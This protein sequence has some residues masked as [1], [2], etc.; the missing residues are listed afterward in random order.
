M[1]VKE[2]RSYNYNYDLFTSPSFLALLKNKSKSFHFKK[3]NNTNTWTKPHTTKKVPMRLHITI[4]GGKILIIWK[5]PRFNLNLLAFKFLWCSKVHSG[6]FSTIFWKANTI[7]W[8]L[9][10]K[11]KVVSA[12]T[13]EHENH[14]AGARRVHDGSSASL[15]SNNSVMLTLKILA[16]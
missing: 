5:K 14:K 11:D 16:N 3:P 9:E 1:Y 6:L 13:K 7:S 2:C 8:Y 10:Q 12:K 4:M 15:N